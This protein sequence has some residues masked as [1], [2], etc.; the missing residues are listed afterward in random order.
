ME[1]QG[2][3]RRVGR[4]ARKS[5]PEGL[6]T[7]SRSEEAWK[8]SGSLLVSAGAWGKYKGSPIPEGSLGSTEGSDI[9]RLRVSFAS[10][11]YLLSFV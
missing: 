4:Q 8:H 11:A 9:N 7:A 10:V 6:A 5:P 2:R 3:G 1:I